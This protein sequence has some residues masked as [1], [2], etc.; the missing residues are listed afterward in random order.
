MTILE[1]LVFA[2]LGSG[3]AWLAESLVPNSVPGGIL[4]SATF[5]IAGA[6]L[7]STLLGSLGPDVAGVSLVPAIFGSI[8]FVFA[9]SI[10]AHSKRA[11]L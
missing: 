8:L 6:W 5:G 9:L 2:C 3:C 11:I 7:G 1:L 4:V 10:G